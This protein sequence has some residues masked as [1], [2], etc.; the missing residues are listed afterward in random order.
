MSYYIEKWLKP[1][2]SPRHPDIGRNYIKYIY[3][4]TSYYTYKQLKP[5][6]SPRHPDTGQNYIIF[7]LL[8]NIGYMEMIEI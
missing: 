6:L 4:K 1:I 8:F 3:K 5:N 7:I 2:L